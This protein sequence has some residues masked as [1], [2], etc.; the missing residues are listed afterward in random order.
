MKQRNYMK[1]R[2]DKDRLFLKMKYITAVS[3]LNI[4][5]EGV[6]CDWHQVEMLR[7]GFY[8]IHPLNFTGAISF[9]GDY[10]IYDNTEFF[11]NKGFKV[12]RV[13]VAT[14]I[15]ALLDILFDAIVVSNINPKHFRMCDYMFDEIDRGEL[16][17]KLNRFGDALSGDQLAMLL[18]W[19][20]ENEI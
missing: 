19:R 10:G 2:K 8:Q 12:S 9:F 17:E 1:S 3:A 5:C 11:T 18:R 7:N 15:R 14:P 4:P 20:D 16:V 13:M 6:Q